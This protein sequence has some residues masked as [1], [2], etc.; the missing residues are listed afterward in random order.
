VP[1]R[2][3]W[4]LLLCSLFVAG[5]ARLTVAAP[6]ACPAP[7]AA[8]ARAAAR[9]GADWLVANQRADGTF[10]YEIDAKGRD[11]GGYDNVRH[12]GAALALYDAAHATHARKYLDAADRAVAW[13]IDRLE[14]RADW[15]ALPDG[16][17]APLGGSALMLSALAERRDYTGDARY[18]DT[19]RA[20]GRFIVAMQKPNG[21]Y[22]VY[23]DL[24]TDRPDPV[25]ISQYY[26]S[27]SLWALARLQNA[28]PDPAFRT[29]ALRAAHFV[30]TERNDRDFVPVGPLNDHWA[31]Y[32]FAEMAKW[33][34]GAE[35][36]AYA[37]QLQARFQL[38]IR[39]DAQKDSGAPYSW[40]H[41]PRR[42]SAALGTW[43]EGQAALARLGSHDSRFADLREPARESAACGAGVL[44]HRQ[45]HG[46]D[47]ATAGA[48]FD[49]GHS[50]VDDQQH[51]IAGL[52]AVAAL[53]DSPE[54]A[55]HHG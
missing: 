7:T 15:H 11:H 41:G 25:S 6:E 49:S 39:W 45:H 13:M 4:V 21:D 50:R 55:D 38:L 42:R 26:A 36:I 54:T 51:S 2:R 8:E 32:G 5:A 48:W 53:V 9:A 52:I 29:S 40:T 24:N 17:T 23:Y 20:L 30:A 33:P 12:A 18:D 14:S 16:P 19:M 35:E 47:P 22:A 44:V 28:L 1:T 46:D 37:R 43:V 31:A 3:L 34:L 27:E 10:A